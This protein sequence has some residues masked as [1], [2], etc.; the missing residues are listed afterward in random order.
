MPTSCSQTK[1]IQT[2]FILFQDANFEQI[3]GNK[4]LNF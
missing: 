4:V 1:A 2:R 3:G